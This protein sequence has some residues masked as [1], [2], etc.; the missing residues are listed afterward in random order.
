M[1]KPCKQS[2]CI[3]SST[4]VVPAHV[5]LAECALVITKNRLIGQYVTN[6]LSLRMSSVYYTTSG[7]DALKEITSSSHYTILITDLLVDEI[8]GIA[9]GIVLK[10]KRSAFV[11]G[12]NNANEACKAVAVESGFDMV[13]DAVNTP[14]VIY[15]CFKVR[16]FL[17]GHSNDLK[18]Y[19]FVA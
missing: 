1:H 7:I 17:P 8:S 11:F 13:Y 5:K 3:D 18:P 15:Q 19:P 2:T 6:V 4:N 14:A 10:E 12:I 9:L 16:D